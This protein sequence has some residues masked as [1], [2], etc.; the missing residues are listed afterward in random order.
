MEAQELADRIGGQ[1]E[2]QSDALLHRVRPPESA[3]DGDLAWI[4]DDRTVPAG[5]AASAVLIGPDRECENLIEVPAI[6]RHSNTNEAFARA[7]LLLHPEPD[8]PFIGI[9]DQARIHPDAHI[10]EHV[11]IGP[12]AF[13]GGEVVVSTEAVIHPGVVIL[14]PT[15]IAAGVTLH[16]NVVIYGNTTIGE[17]TTIHS[18]TVVGGDG[19]GYAQGTDGPCKIPHRGG[20]QISRDVEIGCNCTIDRGALEDTHI[21]E[22]TKI[23]NLVHIAHNVVIGSR[24]FFAAQV[25]IA[26]STV[27]GDDCAF[28]GQSGVVGHVELGSKTQVAAKSAVMRSFEGNQVLMGTPA[29]EAR[30]TRKIYGVIS[31]L[32]E[33]R[34]RIRDLESQ[35]KGL[36]DRS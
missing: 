35:L 3:G 15:T 14:G 2:G 8:P 11:S 18:G 28:G 17:G 32:P 23:D 21:G 16:A 26:G 10:E 20:V 7:I 19:F 36:L 12:G 31:Q 34:E 25:G 33:L 29:A 1:L 6:I 13:I 27:I 22:A 30:Q 9:S 24:C 4:A 5:I